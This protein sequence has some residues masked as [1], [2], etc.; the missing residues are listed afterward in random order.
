MRV[1]VI[2]TSSMGDVL[3]T[4]PALTDANN[5]IKN[6]KFDWIVEDAFSEIPYWHPAV[7]TITKIRMRE[8]K[9]HP[10]KV[11]T[12]GKLKGFISNL[13]AVKYD[14]IIDAQGLLKSGLIGCLCR[15]RKH[16]FDYQSAREGLASITYN[17]K[18][19]INPSQHAITRTRQLFAKALNYSLPTSAP[20]ANIQLQRLKAP[21]IALEKNYILLLP[22]TTWS[23]K[24]WPETY[25][26][27]LVQYLGTLNY[28]IYIPWN[29]ENEKQRALRISHYNENIS[30]L[31]H[32]SLSQ[33]ATIILGATLVIAVDTGLGHLAA[34]L[35]VP[36]L[37]L[38]GPTDP[39]QTGTVGTQQYHLAPIFECAPCKQ[40][41]CSYNKPAVIMPACYS[42]LTPD[43]V[44]QQLEK[45]LISPKKMVL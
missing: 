27:D 10:I 16:G 6:I 41:Q 3:H 26:N 2:K 34:A 35:N 45:L 4:L 36:S 17:K 12:S 5:I 31:P 25:W 43:R 28:H 38:Y 33:L 19:S 29:S 39:K 15:G 20:D 30:V 9:K 40:K 8:W 44:I 1:L 42:R 23:S 7:N 21:D 18:Y 37:S 24:H 11:A 22:N 14:H 32:S 13:R